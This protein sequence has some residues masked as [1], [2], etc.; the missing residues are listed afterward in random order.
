MK[1][2]ETLNRESNI[3][4]DF[5]VTLLQDLNSNKKYTKGLFDS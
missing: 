1:D 2:F 3:S 5:L 4:T